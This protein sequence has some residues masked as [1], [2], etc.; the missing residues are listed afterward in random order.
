[1]FVIMFFSM[2][3]FNDD[4]FWELWKFG[5]R[6]MAEIFFILVGAS[7][8]I[9]WIIKRQALFVWISEVLIVGELIY[10][11]YGN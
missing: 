2:S 7:I 8:L 9:K 3:L 10:W 11:L 6:I 4:L 5:I 1:M